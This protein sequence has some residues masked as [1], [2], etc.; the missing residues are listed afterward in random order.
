MEK[1]VRILIKYFN[2]YIFKRIHYFNNI[3]NS[4][5]NFLRCYH[6]FTIH[7]KLFIYTHSCIEHEYTKID[8]KNEYHT[9]YIEYEN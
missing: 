1:Y 7:V 8:F 9:S 2:D 6:A 4:L 5:I 3:L